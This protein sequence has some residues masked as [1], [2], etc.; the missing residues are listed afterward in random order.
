M[1]TS[2]LY[3]IGTA[4]S[5][6][7]GTGVSVDVLVTGQWLHGHVSALD[8]HGLVLHG[9]DDVLSVLRMDTIS[10]VQVRQASAFEARAEVEA[11]VSDPTVRPMPAAS[12]AATTSG[13][14]DAPDWARPEAARVPEAERSWTGPVRERP[15]L[16][17]AYAF[18]PGPSAIVVP[19]PRTAE[20]PTVGPIVAPYAAPDAGLHTMLRSRRMVLEPVPAA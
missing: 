13:V 18:G 15:D 20:R 10:A 6:A 12:S 8:G 3:T 4:L 16:D 2:T 1:R 11:H 19:S 5:R 17:A 9:D 14:G 7:Q